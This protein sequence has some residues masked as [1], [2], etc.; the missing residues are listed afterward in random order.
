MWRSL[1]HAGVLNCRGAFSD[2]DVWGELEFPNG[3]KS[4]YKR[5]SGPLDKSDDAPGDFQRKQ[6]VVLVHSASRLGTT[7]RFL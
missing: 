7:T 5:F 4:F 3:V 1:V 2:G 6:V